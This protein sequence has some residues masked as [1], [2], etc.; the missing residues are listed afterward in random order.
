M[1]VPELLNN[2]ITSLLLPCPLAAV[3]LSIPDSPLKGIPYTSPRK[4]NHFVPKLAHSF[5][6]LLNL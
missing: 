1:Q 6:P 4:K 2:V 5:S 3:G